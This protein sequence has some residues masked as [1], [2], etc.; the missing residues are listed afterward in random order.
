MIVLAFTIRRQQLIENFNVYRRS[1]NHWKHYSQFLDAAKSMFLSVIA[2]S[3][4]LIKLSMLIT[5]IIMTRLHWERNRSGL[6]GVPASNL[7]MAYVS[8]K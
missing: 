4:N 5:I 2:N 3:V 7:A 6:W 8:K 1:Y